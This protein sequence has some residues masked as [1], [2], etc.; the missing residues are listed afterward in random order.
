MKFR[1]KNKSLYKSWLISYGVILFLPIVLSIIIYSI[2]INVIKDK[3]ISSN[4]ILQEQL[5]RVLDDRIEDVDIMA[6]QIRNNSALNNFLMS[7]Q[8]HSNI[9]RY[10][11]YLALNDFKKYMGTNKVIDDFYVYV[12]ATGDVITS[13][14]LYNTDLTYELFH[15]KSGIQQD[16]WFLYLQEYH[17]RTVKVIKRDNGETAIMMIFSIPINASYTSR[18]TLVLFI[19]PDSLL[20]S[21][22]KMPFAQGTT[23]LLLDE[24][25]NVILS[26]RDVT[27]T[28]DI[29]YENLSEQ[30]DIFYCSVDG[31]KM[32]VLQTTSSKVNWKYVTL[33]SMASITKEIWPIQYYSL[34]YLAISLIMGSLISFGFTRKR[35]QP[36]YRLI[37]RLGIQDHHIGNEYEYL[38]QNI[39]RILESNETKENM[40]KKQRESVQNNYLIS[41][42][43]GRVH[44][45]LSGNETLLSVLGFE[46]KSDVFAVAVF[47]VDSEENVK[48]NIDGSIS[49]VLEHDAELYSVQ[50][51]EYYAILVNF[52]KDID[53]NKSL[54]ILIYHGELI[55][56]D[57]SK[58]I[59][60]CLF[61]VS[62]AYQGLDMIPIAYAES[63][64]DISDTYDE[65]L[66]IQSSANV[67]RGEARKCLLP[68]QE[69]ALITALC[70]GNAKDADK[71]VNTICKKPEKE[72]MDINVFRPIMIIVAGT[73]VKATQSKQDVSQKTL[74]QIDRFIGSLWL[75]RTIEEMINTVKELFLF[76][77]EAI[78]TSNDTSTRSLLDEILSTVHKHYSDPNFNVS[79]MADM[80]SMNLS[81]ISKFFKDNTGIGLN[82]Y[83]NQIRINKAK[84][85]LD[86]NEDISNVL[87]KV[88]FENIGSFIRVFK[89]FVG[90]TPGEYKK[91]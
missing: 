35:Y 51:D 6:Q 70:A 19:N 38:E 43:H 56:N 1:S 88:G 32:M 67:K 74:A 41:L 50:I 85:L 5:T 49:M 29:S 27:I 18:A 33:V 2:S 40:F 63:I 47:L 75:C 21:I 10:N 13:L 87:S 66:S 78:G 69:K 24:S 79:Q 36:V 91:R 30:D 11:I 76:T 12:H 7:N 25:D 9:Q 46:F 22:E 60:K 77:S 44:N 86:R 61:S 58:H 39:D 48:E 53:I 54:Q 20:Q 55:C 3:I 73:A 65:Q 62:K 16:E 34:I 81:Y 71:I 59:G 8:P 28:D 4:E 23:M 15:S 68:E 89:R 31:E 45:L 64:N 72:K 52:N 17:W 14:S 82:M 42:M 57:V 26:N 84:E 90:T 37:R 80:L 83:I